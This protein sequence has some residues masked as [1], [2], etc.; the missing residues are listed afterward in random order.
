LS[1]TALLNA[2]ASAVVGKAATT[3]LHVHALEFVAIKVGA[4]CAAL[5]QLLLCFVCSS[6]QSSEPSSVVRKT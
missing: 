5:C 6:F 4:A 1:I 3:P 2:V